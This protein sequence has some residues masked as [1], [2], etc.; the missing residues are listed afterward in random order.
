MTNSV[1]DT[2]SR[3]PATPAIAYRGMSGVPPTAAFTLTAL[4]PASADPRIASENFTSERVAAIVT[5]TGRSIAALSRH[6]E[7][8]EI[9][10][11]PG[12]LLLP[13]GFVEVENLSEPVVLL[14]ETGWAPELPKNKDELRRTVAEQVSDAFTRPPVHI[15]SPGRFAPAP[16]RRG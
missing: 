7:E 3:L 11:L 6:P 9:A 12:T 10:L 15:F 1:V 2:I 13:V 14:S 4:L 16:S 5:V 8:Q